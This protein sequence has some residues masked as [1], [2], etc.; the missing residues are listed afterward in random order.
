VPEKITVVGDGAWG[1]AVA[2]L[3]AQNP[4]PPRLHLERV[5]GEPPDLDGKARKRAAAAGRA[6]PAVG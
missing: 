5:R 2:L 4:E 3:L 1:T 6:D